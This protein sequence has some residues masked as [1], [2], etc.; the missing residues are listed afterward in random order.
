MIALSE[1]MDQLKVTMSSRAEGV[2]IS[3]D[4]VRVQTQY[5]E[6]PTSLRSSE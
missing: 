5:Q 4:E 2:A 6:I 3:R 1:K